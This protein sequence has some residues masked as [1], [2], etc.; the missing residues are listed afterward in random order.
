[1]VAVLA[2]VMAAGWAVPAGAA[3][4]FVSCDGD[5][6]Y[7][8]QRAVD[9]A[10]NGDTLVVTTHGCDSPLISKDLTVM[11]FFTFTPKLDGT[12]RVGG[13]RVVLDNL[14]LSSWTRELLYVW[15]GTVVARHLDMSGVQAID[16]FDVARGAVWIGAGSTAAIEDS[17]IDNSDV[18]GILNEGGLTLRGVTVTRNRG[19]G[20]RNTGTLAIEAS[21]ISSNSSWLLEGGVFNEGTLHV[22]RST[23]SDNAAGDAGGGIR[24]A[25]NLTVDQSAVIRNKAKSF[26]GG[27]SM[28]PGSRADITASTFSG[29]SAYAG[30]GIWNDDATVVLNATTISGNSASTG[31]GGVTGTTGTVW[32]ES[33]VLSA[34]GSSPCGGA[35]TWASFGGNYLASGCGPASPGP[36]DVTGSSPMLAEL[37]DNGGPTLTMKPLPGSPLIDKGRCIGTLDQRSVFKPQTGACDIGAYE[38]RPPVAPNAP[39]FSVASPTNG[40]FSVV[41]SNTTDRDGDPI[42]YR[43]ERRDAD[44]ADWTLDGAV[45]PEG[46]LRFRLVAS[47]RNAE[48]ASPSSTA[49]VV[50]RTAPGLP[51]VVADRTPEYV[52][53]EGS[54]WYADKTVVKVTPGADPALP[55]GTAGSGTVSPAAADHTYDTAGQHVTSA[56][57]RD[58]V[59]NESY[60][61]SR[62]VHVDTSAP[63]LALEACPSEVLLGTTRSIGWTA[64]DTGSGLAGAASGSQAL[65]TSAVGTRSVRVE[66]ADRVGHVGADTCSYEVVYAFGGFDA[67]LRATFPAINSVGAG[68]VVAVRFSLGGDHGLGVLEGDP[69]VTPIA[70][71]TKEPLGDARTATALRPFSYDGGKYTFW[72]QTSSEWRRTCARFTLALDDGTTHKANI[73]FR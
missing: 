31:G 37:A 46:T 41:W 25:G 38:N 12:L 33:T 57:S 35:L 15:A 27:L 9:A 70:C 66:A 26:G 71:D 55:D 49:M 3:T 34:N 52:D 69:T 73:S 4:K 14:V 10:A 23:I 36:G 43:M 54:E 13:G 19:G 47:D 32:V 20:I 39:T 63:E 5:D 58:A 59:G 1:M 72:W 30:G 16:G 67:P 22:R 28:G 24:N 50:D 64:S 21:T 40:L 56:R 62:T 17:K 18:R 45:R 11:G 2:S 8:L 60:A 44:D 42:G 68:Q 29:N 7:A 6:H 61:V 53:G 48:T 51:S 65:D